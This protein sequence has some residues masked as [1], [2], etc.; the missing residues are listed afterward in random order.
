MSQ[1]W[2]HRHRDYTHLRSHRPLWLLALGPAVFSSHGH[3]APWE[4]V[5]VVM[6]MTVMAMVMVVTVLTQCQAFHPPRDPV[7]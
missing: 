7:G 6:M 5:V 2:P 3:L 4:T 1:A